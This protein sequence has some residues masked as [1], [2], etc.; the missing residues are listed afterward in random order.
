MKPLND[1][2]SNIIAGMAL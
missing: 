1:L 2:T